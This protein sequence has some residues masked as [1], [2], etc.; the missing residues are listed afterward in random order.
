ME[1]LTSALVTGFSSGATEALGVIT[2]VVPVVMPVGV[3]IVVIRV[4]WR[5]FKMLTGRG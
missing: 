3:G 2:D 5:V 4:G 1:A